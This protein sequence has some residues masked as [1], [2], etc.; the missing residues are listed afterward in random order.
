MPQE[1]ALTQGSAM[2]DNVEVE[3]G[4]QRIDRHYG[5]WLENWAE[6][7]EPNVNREAMSQGSDDAASGP[8][9][10]F[11]RMSGMGGVFG[12]AAA[13]N[14]VALYRSTSVLVLSQPRSCFTTHCSPVPRS[15]N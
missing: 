11:Q 9:T 5:H 1:L 4:G 3:I 7:T 6:L 14:T 15:Q 12:V 10:L 13:A 8:G 2:I